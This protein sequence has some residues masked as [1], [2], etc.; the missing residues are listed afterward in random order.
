MV[1]IAVLFAK[2]FYP[3]PVVY[4]Q[5]KS[6]MKAG[7]EVTIYAWDRSGERPDTEVVEGIKV[8]NIHAKC[9]YGDMKEIMAKLPIY[10]I[11]LMRKLDAMDYDVLHCYDQYTIAIGAFLSKLHGKRLV[12]DVLDIYY[13]DFPDG[14][15][16]SLYSSIDRFFASF[17]DAIKVPCDYFRSYYE[18]ED[19]T[20]VVYNCPE[21]DRF[22][23]EKKGHEGFAIGHFGNIRWVEPFELLFEAVKGMKDVMVVVGGEGIFMDILRDKARGIG[24]IDIQGFVP[25]ENVP[26]RYRGIDAL[27]VVYPENHAPILYSVP[28]KIFEAMACGIPV[29]VNNIGFTADFVKKNGIGLTVN[30]KDPTDIRRA[31]LRLKEDED[32]RDKMGKR[33][34]M[35]VEREYNW[36]NM[37]KRLLKMY[38]E[39]EKTI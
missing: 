32:L 20:T 3:H 1:R 19:K 13:L 22:T 15:V 11:K 7:H 35:L 27:Y 33:G 14:P 6:L 34:R 36:E 39:M 4:R 25:F 28:M 26:E 12:Y 29:I 31:V 10:Y 38:E 23:P 17:S 8:V 16:K 30:G 21:K 37:E 18:K 24:N 2:E 5:S 9:S